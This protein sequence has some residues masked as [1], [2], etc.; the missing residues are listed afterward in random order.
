MT[1]PELSTSADT[2]RRLRRRLREWGPLTLLYLLPGVVLTWPL[3]GRMSS[4]LYGFGNDNWGGIW[5]AQWIHRAFWGPERS[6]FSP[7]LMFPQGYTV[8]PRYI[9]PYDR[10][11]D[12]LFG[13]IAHGLF[14]YNL[15]T[16][17]TFPM[18]GL[19]MYALA[20][21]LTQNRPASVVAGFLYTITPFHLA[22]A[23]QYPPMAAVYVAPL[24]VLALIGM[25][26][27]RRL[28]DAF[29]VGAAMAVVWATSYYY[30]WFA[31]WFAV[32]FTI[33]AALVG[34]V[35]AIRAREVWS[36]TKS[37]TRFIVTRGAWSVLAFLLVGGPMLFALFSQ[38]TSNPDRFAR[39]ADDVVFTAVRPWQYLLPSA[40]N[41]V[42]G[43]ADV[44]N[45]HVSVLPIYEQDNY[46][47]ILALVLA[48]AALLFA[49]R[50]AEHARASFVPLLAGGAFLFLVTLG[51]D[52][53]WNVFSIGDWLS[54]S[55]NSH[56][57]GPV[58]YLYDL[59][60][61][62]RYYG[63]AY[64]FISTTVIAIAAVGLAILLRR[65]DRPGRQW[66]IAGLVGVLG[67]ID[68]VGLP[69]ERFVSL[70]PQPWVA[71]VKRLPA[72]APIMQYP[73]AGYSTPRSLQYVYWQSQHDHPTVNPPETPEQQ[74]FVQQ[75][76]DPNSFLTGQRLSKAGVRFAVIH[77]KLASPTF[78]P[79]QPATPSDQMPRDAGARNPWFREYSRT[80]DAVIYEIL[81]A[82][83]ADRDYLEVSLDGIWD[84]PETE[85]NA[86]WRWLK[87]SRGVV[88]IYSSKAQ[89]RARI[90]FKMTT[91]AKPR[92]L[93]MATG[94]IRRQVQLVPD[95][96]TTVNLPVPIARG[97]TS[98][99][100][101]VTPG[102][103][104]VDDVFHTGDLREIS[105][106]V[107]IPLTVRTGRSR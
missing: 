56:W 68:F 84:K 99:A 69:R 78:P 64:V 53:P 14:V 37:G 98:I 5:Y 83:R 4:G 93:T 8:D 7:D 16:L 82:P 62:F 43:T 72:N 73:A 50:A 25:F 67:F 36:A 107:Q 76:E 29:W 81:K 33:G 27:H 97:T 18:A 106:R 102:P 101:S 90:T 96:I 10:V 59:S 38:V 41:P 17:L 71:A 51:P 75:V 45:R 74:L 89:P 40:D 57:T 77:T 92:T 39:A 22:M 94:R 28:R 58:E 49:R 9:Q 19:A 35:R 80:S 2:D 103:T 55:T 91:F 6:T 95:T 47:G 24:F 21:S 15:L 12:I 105:L 86:Q 3:I 61:N 26:R 20:R 34:L 60:P 65:V 48:L 23:T 66:A 11:M 85:A 13:G 63:R 54:P 32:A 52:I 70:K 46:L 87:A 30:G 31:I 42:F 100:L 1:S 79:Y 104:K 44:I 88:S